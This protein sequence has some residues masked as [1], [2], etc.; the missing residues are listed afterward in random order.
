MSLDRELGL[1]DARF[2]HA[3]PMRQSSHRMRMLEERLILEEQARAFEARVLG[4]V[5]DLAASAI[6][7]VVGR[8]S[9]VA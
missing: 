6:R 3:R 8:F 9:R 4:A 7:H 2:L 1:R 5:L